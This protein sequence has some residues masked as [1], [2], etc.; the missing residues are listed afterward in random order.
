LEETV[1]DVTSNR[2]WTKEEIKVIKTEGG[3]V[4]TKL[5]ASKLNRTPS[6]VRSKAFRV[7]KSL[8]PVK[9][10]SKFKSKS[11]N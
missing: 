2:E 7:G 1:L 9:S 5:I 10:K 8:E 3:K 11:K 4:P 6:A